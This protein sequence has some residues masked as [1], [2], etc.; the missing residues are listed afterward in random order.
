M[1]VQ[2]KSWTPQLQNNRLKLMKM[3][4]L[5]LIIYIGLLLFYANT[6]AA[7]CKTLECTYNPQP[8]NDDFSLP[9][10]GGLQMIFKKVIVPGAEFWGNPERI[11]KVGDAQGELAN[12]PMSAM[13]EGAQTLPISGSFYDWNKRQWYYYLG[14]YE[15]S[16]AQFIMVMGNGSQAKGLEKFYELSGDS[17]FNAQLKKAFSKNNKR[18]QRQLLAMPLTA[19]SWFDYQDFIRQYNHWCYSTPNCMAKLPKLPKRLNANASGAKK[20]EDLPG[21]FRLPT[22]LEWEYAARGG[23]D[24]L[25]KKDSD[26][27]P[28]FE[29]SLPFER[30]QF[31][32]FAWA[33]PKSKG[34]APT[35][36]GRFKPTRGGFFDLFGN[37]QEL[38][39]QMF[40]TELIQGKVGALSL[41]GGSFTQ[42]D[43]QIRVS[44]RTELDIYKKSV[45]TGEM[46]ET[47]SHTTGIRLAIGS[48]VIRTKQFKEDIEKQ[49]A[50]YK[51]GTYK[52]TPVGRSSDDA[53]MNAGTTLQSAMNNLKMDNRRLKNKSQQM[54]N[55]LAARQLDIQAA[56]TV[57]NELEDTINRLDHQMKSALQQAHKKIE[58]GTLDVCD[59]LVSNAALISKTAGWHY[60]RASLK[61]DLIEKIK[62][63]DIPGKARNIHMARQ[64]YQELMD[65]F[66]KH[67]SNYVQTVEKLGRYSYRFIKPAIKKKRKSHANDIIMLEFLKLLEKHVTS[68]MNGVVDANG[69]KKDIQRLSLEKG[70]FIN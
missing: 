45:R 48:L 20:Y 33:K 14:K 24:A 67:F 70:I 62:R 32:K 19:V 42:N 63:M 58:E 56:K 43:Y 50:A 4:P 36:I 21:F 59:K 25:K 51:E 3:K 68:A 9:M 40:R 49:Y 8:S 39:A 30:N 26:G 64:N 61:K 69:W 53:L 13:F 17:K 34:K 15:V 46:I 38:M 31:K 35:I 22:E 37:V 16:L 10:P 11:V 66:Q 55:L 57:I 18:K 7:S 54:Q 5:Y 23:H 2:D 65:G 29:H 28:V 60:A 27:R 47:R 1:D 6:A 44:M 52:Q 41:R 12:D